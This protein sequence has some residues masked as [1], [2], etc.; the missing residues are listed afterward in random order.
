MNLLS[1]FRILTKILAVIIMLSTVAA[2]ITWF[3]TRSL[4]ELND[5][6]GLMANAARRSLLAARA[7]QNARDFNRAELRA[8]LNPSEENHKAAVRTIGEQI[9]QFDERLAE[10]SKTPDAKA[11]ELLPAVHENFAAY[12]M[13]LD[14]TLAL[15][16]AAKDD[17]ITARAEELSA[18]AMKSSSASDKLQQSLKVL[19]DR[20]N[21]RVEEFA[22]AATVEYE[23]KSRLMIGLAVSGILAGLF[24]GF[25]VGQYGIAK[26]M[27]A[28]VHLLQRMAKGETVEMIGTER[29]DEVGETARAVDDI[30]MML[31]EK[32]RQEAAAKAE[33]DRLQAEIRRSEMHRLASAFEGAVGEI[34]ETVSSASTELEASAGSMTTTAQRTQHVTTTVAA[35][36][37]EASANVQSVAS[38]SEELAASVNEISRQVQESSRI[39]SEAVEQAAATNVQISQL[40][41]AAGRIGDV[42]ELIHGIAAQTNLLALNATIEAARAGE[43]GRG[44]AVVAS[45][46]KALAEQTAKA[47]EEIS[48]Q[49]IEMQ[50][51][52]D[53]SVTTI[54]TI[55]DTINKMSE[56]ASAIASAVEEQGAATNEISCNIQHAAKGVEQV[57]SG[58]VEVQHGAAETGSASAQVLTSAKTLS[59]DSTRLKDEVDKFL[60]TVRAA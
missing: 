48:R 35:A 1:R 44:F 22:E 56:I 55:S 40:S 27:R 57:S 2:T 45:E 13:E 5:G 23:S 30:K 8:A 53:Q 28:L 46:V 38:A 33:Q 9:A 3:A 25:L 26:P 54:R 17:K 6:A 16:A 18:A 43:S 42:I 10:I 7:N 12:K 60:G 50:T 39:A 4:S 34:V 58:I 24:L 52:T 32:A 36:S 11:Q 47:T 20:L 14:R 19:A 15:I 37:D 31:M 21:D 59:R 51:A 49:V 29:G 41:Q